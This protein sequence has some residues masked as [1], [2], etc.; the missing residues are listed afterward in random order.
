VIGL[1]RSSDGLD[2]LKDLSPSLAERGQFLIADVTDLS[3]V[4]GAVKAATE[5]GELDVLVNCAGITEQVP[6][7]KMTPERW[8]RMFA[9][10][11]RGL[12]FLTQAVAEHMRANGY[13]RIVNLASGAAKSAR[14]NGL[15]Y[16]A[17]KAGVVSLTR[18]LAKSLAGQGVC[19]NAICPGGVITEMAVKDDGWG[20]PGGRAAQRLRDDPTARPMLPQEVASLIAFLS[21]EEAEYITGQAINIDAGENMMS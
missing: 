11:L 2:R 9:V 6:W 3:D 4:Q 5:H 1:D 21:S 12:F 7:D 17:S 8:D 20:L 10:N 18:S 13:G 14:P 15:H 16:A 19:V